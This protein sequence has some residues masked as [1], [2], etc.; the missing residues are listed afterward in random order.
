MPL[1]IPLPE[2]HGGTFVKGNLNTV[3]GR[4]ESLWSGRSCK[5]LRR[6]SRH[7]AEALAAVVRAPGT[8][9]HRA[10]IRISCPLP[11]Q[12]ELA[13]RCGLRLRSRT[14]SG[15]LQNA[16]SAIGR[17]GTTA[18]IMNWF[19]CVSLWL[20]LLLALWMSRGWIGLFFSGQLLS[21]GTRLVKSLARKTQCAFSANSDSA[22]RL[23]GG[24]HVP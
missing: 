17:S 22:N 7:D 16:R 4:L 23:E 11:E 20:S 12:M 3:T 13:F 6:P 24:H 21:A 2:L 1:H 8:S 18:L 14:R 19:F 9:P 5:L 15:G 10:R